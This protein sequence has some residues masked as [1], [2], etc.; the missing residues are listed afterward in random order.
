MVHWSYKA[1][2]NDNE[3][4][5]HGGNPEYGTDLFEIEAYGYHPI[6]SRDRFCERKV[7]AFLGIKSEQETVNIQGGSYQILKV[8]AVA[9]NSPAA[10][11]GFQPGNIIDRFDGSRIWQEGFSEQLQKKKPGDTVLIEGYDY[12][13][14]Q[15]RFTRW[16]T[17]GAQP[18]DK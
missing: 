11:T 15:T 2:G 4:E 1:T 13:G 8:T 10:A 6:V 7:F 9:P 5:S 18:V 16:V 17:L 12:S 3:A 14:S